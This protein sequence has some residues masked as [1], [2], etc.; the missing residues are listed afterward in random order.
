MTLTCPHSD[1][2]SC[3]QYLAQGQRCQSCPEDDPK[4]GTTR[5]AIKAAWQECS[6]VPF[7]LYD[8]EADAIARAAI[9]ALEGSEWRPIE[10]APRD[11]TEVLGCWDAPTPE[12]KARGVLIWDEHYGNWISIPG[13]W[14]KEP[15]HW[16]PLPAPPR[17]QVDGVAEP[18]ERDG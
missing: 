13:H 12:Y 1:G 8:S 14:R 5:E 9:A 3:A 10:T 7:P 2:N 16:R 18:Q 15:T 4:V 11:G 6:D 17:A